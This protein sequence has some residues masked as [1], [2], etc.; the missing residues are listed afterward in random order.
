MPAEPDAVAAKLNDLLARL[1]AVA[2]R[3]RAFTADVAH[4][5]R[6]PLAGARTTLEVA[7]RRERRAE[8]YAEALRATL[9]VLG[10]MEQMV[11]RPL[12]LARLDRG[13]TPRKRRPVRLGELVEACWASVSA[14]ARARGIRFEQRVPG[15]LGCLADPESVIMV[16]SNLLENAVEYTPPGGRVWVGARREGEGLEACVANTGC[17]LTPE[18][19]GRVFDRFWRRDPSRTD[20]GIHAGLGLAIVERLVSALGGC[21]RARRR[22]GDIFEVCLTLPAATPP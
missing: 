6:T 1:E 20:T 8:Q 17:V 7:L 11:E 5:V 19:M 3:E 2:E 14:R 4:E 22:D 16:F 21:C 13:G 9:A 18:E 10:R 12:F 15:D